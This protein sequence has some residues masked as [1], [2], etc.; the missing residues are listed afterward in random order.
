[1][2]NTSTKTW[3]AV[4]IIA[5]TLNSGLMRQCDEC[6]LKRTKRSRLCSLAVPLILFL[7]AAPV[8][9]DPPTKETTTIT[10]THEI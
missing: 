10:Q 2:F 4:T 6:V 1:M 9:Q 7:L 3:Q 8:V 5:M